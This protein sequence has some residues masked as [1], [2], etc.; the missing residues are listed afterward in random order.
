M[1]IYLWLLTLTEHQ[2]HLLRALKRHPGVTLY[3]VVATDELTERKR[4]GWI[5]PDLSDINVTNV[6]KLNWIRIGLKLVKENS[7]AIHLFGGLWASRRFFLILLYSMYKN[8]F[9]G[10][11]VEPFIDT[12]DGYLD[13][14]GLVAGWLYSKLRPIIY[15]VSGWALDRKVKLIFAIS[16]KAACQFKKAGFRSGDLYPFGYFVPTSSHSVK[17]VEHPDR[18]VLRL[19][20][21]GALISRKGIDFIK[22]LAAL[23]FKKR[24]PISIDVYGPGKQES[25]LNFS[26]NLNYRGVIAFGNSSEVMQNYDLLIVPSKFDGWGVVVN[27]ALQSGLPILVSKNT[28]ASTL[29]TQSGAGIVFDSNNA[30]ELIDSI[31]ALIKDRTII[32]AWKERALAYSSKITPEIAASYMLKSINS[33]LNGTERPLS[34]WYSI[35]EQRLLTTEKDKKSIVFFHRKPHG[36]NFSLEIAFKVLRDAMPAQIVCKVA[37]SRYKSTGILRRVF[38]IFEASFRQGDVNHITGDV[39]FLSYL[40]RRNK[41]ILTILDF[42]FMQNSTGLKR[43]IMLLLWGHLP[44]K[45]VKIITVISEST[46]REALKYLKCSPDKIRVVPISISPKFIRFDKKFNSKKPRILQIGTTPNKNLIRLVHALQN[47]P[48]KLEIMGKLSIDQLN[49]LRKN[50]IDYDNF[51]NLTEEEVLIRYRESDM[52]AFVSTYEGFGMPILEANATGRAVITSNIFSMP[53]VAGKAGCLVD[54]FN[55]AEIRNGIMRII[56]DAS[57]REDLILNG[58]I[59]VRRFNPT[60]VASQYA[61]IYQELYSN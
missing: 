53:E 33:T 20:F 31:E 50:N 3:V 7:D 30:C 27:E 45:R 19:V 1:K 32:S 54:P 60:V 37:E 23:C 5:K 28:G 9:L 4:Q 18:D 43:K 52:V 25:L 42:V 38:N 15:R 47:I 36:N 14:E 40:L 22:E 29:V 35:S 6:N 8:R 41:T 12:K 16:S 46:K 24:V 10:L 17:M 59:N 2:V 26:P 49:A 39:H 11:I 44:E 34:S 55:S 57:Y 13:D 48:C 61:K 56:E 58:F 21:I 51:F